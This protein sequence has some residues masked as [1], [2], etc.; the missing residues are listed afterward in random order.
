MFRAF[1]FSQRW[2]VV[3]SI[4]LISRDVKLFRVLFSYP[5]R[6]L[7]IQSIILI[8]REGRVRSLHTLY[9]LCD[10]LSPHPPLVIMMIM[11]I[12]RMLLITMMRTKGMI[13][14]MNCFTDWKFLKRAT[15]LR[16]GSGAFIFVDYYP[17]SAVLVPSIANIL[18]LFQNVQ[19]QQRKVQYSFRQ[20]WK[21]Y[22]WDGKK[23]Q[24]SKKQGV[25]GGGGWERPMDEKVDVEK[26]ESG[27][28]PSSSHINIYNSSNMNVNID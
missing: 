16:F 8:L 25:E 20:K 9:T 28:P 21:Q 18:I 10:T 15:K 19:C 6:C 17:N 14:W 5:Q 26:L 27:E 13:P 3:Q 23:R 12:M 2:L 22:L 1:F 11:I 7:D 24:I 4:I